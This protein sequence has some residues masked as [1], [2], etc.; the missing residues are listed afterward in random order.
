M[1][2]IQA[3]V[4]KQ[5][6]AAWSYRW[7][8]VALTWL[9]C[10]GGWFYAMRV[11]N[12]YESSARLYIDADAILTPLLRGLTIEPSLGAQLELLQRTLLS[13]PNL[14]KLISKTDLELQVYTPAERVALADSL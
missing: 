9:V 5:L 4:L 1:Y 12:V 11:P 8:A 10:A 3:L 6:K 2:Q 14:A 13:R 7:P